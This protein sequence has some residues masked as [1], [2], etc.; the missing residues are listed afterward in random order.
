MKKT[1]LICSI[2]IRFKMLFLLVLI[3]FL[4]GCVTHYELMPEYKTYKD[5]IK[6]IAL[7]QMHLNED[8]DEQRRFKDVF[9]KS[10]FNLLKSMPMKRPIEFIQMDK[11]L[12]YFYTNKNINYDSKEVDGAMICDLTHYNEVDAGTVLAQ[13]VGSKLASKFCFGGFGGSVSEKNELQM[14]ITLFNASNKEKLWEYYADFSKS[15]LD[16]ARFYFTKEV[17][18]EFVEYFPYS[19]EFEGD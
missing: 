1:N 12:K 4:S 13:K 8:G 7:F 15:Y 10:F 6:T 3:L 19:K 16:N 11:S 14:K 2:F 18:E 9:S 5:Q 17:M